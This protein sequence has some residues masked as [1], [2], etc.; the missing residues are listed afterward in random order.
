MFL[1]L[2]T[3]NQNAQGQEKMEKNL[4]T[5][6]SSQRI[7]T[8]MCIKHLRFTNVERASDTEG[9]DYTENADQNRSA[10]TGHLNS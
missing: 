7:I 5:F 2:R 9:R 8:V 3:Q 6:R 10:G 4:L 1:P